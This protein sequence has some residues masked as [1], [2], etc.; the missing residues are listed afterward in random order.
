[1][2]Q[3]EFEIPLTRLA[4]H[5]EP[6]ARPLAIVRL[7]GDEQLAPEDIVLPPCPVIGIGDPDHSLARLCD[8][9]VEGPVGAAGLIGNVLRSPHAAAAVV[10]LLRF[11]PDLSPEQ[12]L[13]AESMAYAMLQGSAE[14]H[15]WRRSRPVAEESFAPGQVRIAHRGSGVDV[16]LCRE[17]AGNAIDTAMRDELS[18]VFAALALDPQVRRIRLTGEGKAFSLGAEL[19]EFGTTLDPATAHEIRARTLPARQVL[20]CADRLEAFVDG[21]C[22]GAGLEIA[23]F[24]RRIEATPRAWF[25]LPELAMGI[26]PGAGGCV[27]LTRRMGRQRTALMILSGRRLGA[28]KALEWG[29]VDSLVDNRAFDESHRDIAAE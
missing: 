26:L 4:P 3:Q 17:D 23:A 24:A 22:V 18:R 1:M 14:H 20:R 29:L 27:S 25:Q 21:A 19:S 13:D 6:L 7:D 11:L 15:A 28:R 16:T 12:G 5:E 10:Q 8:A 2:L 9:M